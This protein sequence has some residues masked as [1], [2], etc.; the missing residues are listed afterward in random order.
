MAQ[1]R[2]HC[3]APVTVQAWE[4]SVPP[5][6]WPPFVYRSDRA[7][8]L[9]CRNSLRPHKAAALLSAAMC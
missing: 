7:Q 3:L 8:I 9:R 2:A 6:G 4:V 5:F 1:M